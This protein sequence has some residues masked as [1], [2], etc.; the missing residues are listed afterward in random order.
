[1]GRLAELHRLASCLVTTPN[2]AV[3][4]DGESIARTARTRVA[5]ESLAMLAPGAGG[6]LGDLCGTL[7][8]GGRELTRAL[9]YYEMKNR[10][11][12][13]GQAGAPIERS[14]GGTR[15][16]PRWSASMTE[17]A[18]PPRRES[19][20]TAGELSGTREPA[21]TSRSGLSW[22]SRCAGGLRTV[23]LLAGLAE[24][25]A[26]RL[27][28]VSLGIRQVGCTAPTYRCL[29]PSRQVT[30]SPRPAAPGPGMGGDSSVYR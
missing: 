16:L 6:E 2:Q 8:D 13:I 23:E 18:D 4:D 21:P 22:S 29:R 25:G 5:L 28:P 11:G 26:R 10:A 9:S 1:M 19:S 7:W 24:A 12:L 30:D 14:A 17:P 3:D 20:G 15:T 27:V